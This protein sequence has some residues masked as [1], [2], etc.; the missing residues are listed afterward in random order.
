M[1]VSE[2]YVQTAKL[3]FEDSLEDGKNFYHSANRALLQVSLVRPAIGSCVI[4]HHPLPNLLGDLFSPVQ[5]VADLCFEAAGAKSFYFE[6]DGNGHCVVEMEADGEWTIISDIVLASANREFKP[7]RGFVKKGN[8]FAPGTVRLRFIGEYLYQVRRIAL[9]GALYSAEKADIPAFS[10]FVSYSLPELAKDFIDFAMPPIEEDDGHTKAGLGY[11]I[12]GKNILLPY[13]KSG[14][15]RVLYRK[16]P[17]SIEYRSDPEKDGTVIDLDEELCTLLPILV[18]AYVW[19]EDEEGK[20]AYY[21]DLYRERAAQIE[22]KSRNAAPSI[23]K[24]V[25]GW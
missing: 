24:N 18:A 9:Y 23:V 2:L 16:K 25:Y 13:N 7:Y 15:V 3:G 6:A 5:R 21:M 17:K 22:R 19:L 12:E 10:P 8:E 4:N 11:A 1:T 14:V 20:A